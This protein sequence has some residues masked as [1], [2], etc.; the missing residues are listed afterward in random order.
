MAKQKDIIREYLDRA[1]TKRVMRK[2]VAL[3]SAVVLLFTTSRLTNIAET[4][5]WDV[6]GGPISE[7]AEVEKTNEF[8][9]S[10]QSLQELD[11]E[12]E[13]DQSVSVEE[14]NTDEVIE[15]KEQ[16]A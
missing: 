4:I 3:L 13:N 11:I 12:F 10:D 7:T 1:N 5:G 9:E 15:E 2:W 16:S 8:A 14:H 6:E